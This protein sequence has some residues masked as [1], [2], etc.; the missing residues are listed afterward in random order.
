M[1][2]ASVGCVRAGRA[3]EAEFEVDVDDGRVVV[4]SDW[5]VRH[6]LKMLSEIGFG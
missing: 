3:I 5:R 1:G 6:V 2:L 4:R